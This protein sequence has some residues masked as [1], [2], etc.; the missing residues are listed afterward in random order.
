MVLV[1]GGRVFDTTDGAV[2]VIGTEG[3][4]LLEDN[5]VDEITGLATPEEKDVDGNDIPVVVEGGGQANAKVE[6]FGT[7]VDV[8]AVDGS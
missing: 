8:I 3:K 6:R 7:D 2:E 4:V 1:F 5:V